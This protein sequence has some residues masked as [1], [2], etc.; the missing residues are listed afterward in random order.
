MSNSPPPPPFPPLHSYFALLL[1]L[2]S[3]AGFILSVGLMFTQDP[4]AQSIILQIA[5]IV[6]LIGSQWISQRSTDS[7]RFAPLMLIV[8]FQVDF[9]QICLFLSTDLFGGDWWGMII[10]TEVAS[11]FKNCGLL[12][13]F[14][15][16]MGW[17]KTDPYLNKQF[18]AMLRAR[19]MIDSLSEV[20]VGLGAFAYY[21]IEKE[22][23]TWEGVVILNVTIPATNDE[24]ESFFRTEPCTITCIGWTVNEGVPPP[25]ADELVPTR[26]VF[27][28][29]LVVT[30]VRVIFLMLETVLLNKMELHAQRRKNA[31]V[32]P[33]DGEE[34]GEVESSISMEGP[35]FPETNANLAEFS[36]DPAKPTVT[37][38]FILVS[39]MIA[40]SACRYGLSSMAF[41]VIL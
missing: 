10:L 31:S 26:A 38:L 33:A 1:Y 25:S 5:S 27:G 32:A 8:Y 29:M 28:I 4:V 36:P 12:Q 37:T 14:S 18:M 15:Y 6:F 3:S 30:V 34:D 2:F 13:M 11:L 24:V 40:M 23:R 39:F 16:L 41:T 9:F 35:S 21:A 22:S 17:R 20:L 7:E 19:G